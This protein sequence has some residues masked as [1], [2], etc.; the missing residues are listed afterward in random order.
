MFNNELFGAT[1]GVSLTPTA[2]AICAKL[3]GARSTVRH[4]IPET[5]GFDPKSSTRSRAE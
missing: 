4:S 2:G 3:H 1:R 5:R